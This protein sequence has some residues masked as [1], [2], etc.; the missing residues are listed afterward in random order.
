MVRKELPPPPA[1]HGANNPYDEHFMR[2]AIKQAKKVKKNQL[3]IGAV[4]VRNG[5]VIGRGHAKDK[6][7]CDPTNHAE[8]VAIRKACKEQ[9]SERLEG[10]TIYTTAEPCQMC[11]SV[12]FQTGIREIIFGVHRKDLP[13]RKKKIQFGQLVEDAGYPVETFGG[14]LESEI[15]KLFEPDGIKHKIPIHERFIFKK[16]TA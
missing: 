12:I 8:I 14:I 1:N 10:C 9:R 5:E 15:L 3:P 16:A 11:S 6:H 2:E 7:T 13:V 4:V